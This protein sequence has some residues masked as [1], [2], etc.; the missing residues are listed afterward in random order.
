M[1]IQA[2]L[3][4][5]IEALVNDYL[6]SFPEEL[7]PNIDELAD[8]TMSIFSAIN[9]YKGEYVYREYVRQ[10][11]AELFPTLY[12]DHYY[13]FED[14]DHSSYV[15]ELLKRPQ[16]VQRSSEWYALRMN[17]VGASE[18]GT[19]FGVN[20][21][22]NYNG[23]LIKKCGYEAPFSSKYTQHGVMFEPVVQDYYGIRNG[24]PLYEFGSLLHPEIPFVSA[25]PDG[26]TPKGVMVEIKVPPKRQIM[27]VPPIYYWCQMQQQMQVCNLFHVDFVECQFRQFDTWSEFETDSGADDCIARGIILEYYVKESE[28][29]RYEYSPIEKQDLEQLD[30]WYDA[31]LSEIVEREKTHAVE[32]HMFRFWAMT[33]YSCCAVWRDDNWWNNNMSEYEKFWKQV[34]HHRKHGYEHL[35]PKKK[36]YTKKGSLKDTID[37]FRDD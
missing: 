14:K 27:G 33:T 36:T 21:Y 26:I 15:K 17:S 11:I 5:D 35:I 6:Q 23:L 34:E 7:L 3:R 32:M 25:S 4:G 20:P 12:G 37:Y 1:S 16:P 24:C 18:S 31:K 29:P 28:N 10:L 8:Y 13:E 30:E 2:T 19:L 22:E 9:E